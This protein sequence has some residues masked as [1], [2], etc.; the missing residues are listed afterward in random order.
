MEQTG[1]RKQRCTVWLTK[2]AVLKS[3]A[4][5]VQEELPTRSDYI[6][7]AIHFYAGHLAMEHNTDYI[8]RAIHESVSGTVKTSENRLAR[9]LFKI[10]VEMAKL[11]QMLA[12]INEM[13]EETLRRLHIRCVNDVKKINGIIS[14]EDAVKFQRGEEE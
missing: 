1:Y 5:M 13:D 9:L 7:Q 6:E 2:E 3:D 12:T 14:M 8:A 10:A 4:G 11:E